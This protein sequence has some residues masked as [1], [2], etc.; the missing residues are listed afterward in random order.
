MTANG[1]SLLVKM[2]FRWLTRWYCR[3]DRI[4]MPHA[5]ALVIFC[6]EWD[7]Q[8]GTGHLLLGLDLPR[9][10]NLRP[11]PSLDGVP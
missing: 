1:L 4:G 8:R 10:P 3:V 2:D 5:H 6:L 11:H 7:F 9:G